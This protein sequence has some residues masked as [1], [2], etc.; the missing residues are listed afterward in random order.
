[1]PSGRCR[2][3]SK[4]SAINSAL[5]LAHSIPFGTPVVPEV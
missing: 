4:L 3:P 5:R 2:S 1:M